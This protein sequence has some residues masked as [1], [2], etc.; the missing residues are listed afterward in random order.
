MSNPNWSQVLEGTFSKP[1]L[2]RYAANPRGA[3]AAIAY[4]H[5]MLLAEAIMPCLHVLEVALRNAVHN[6][7]RKKYSRPDW[8]EEAAS[9][10]DKDHREIKK[11]KEHI[12]GKGHALT[13][14]KVVSEL[15][16][17]FWVSLFNTRHET[18]FWKELRMAFP[19][20]PKAKR[21]RKEISKALSTARDLRNRAAHHD[22][23]LWL[24]PDMR[25]QYLICIDIIGWIDPQLKPW[26]SQFD[27][28]LQAWGNWME[29]P[30]AAQS[31]ITTKENPAHIL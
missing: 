21:Q 3:D 11:T 13:P 5:N 14:D 9:L 31:V 26:L 23:L 19:R 15:N 30:K 25:N 12:Q 2:A 22:A 16:F 20:C 27:K 10:S 6:A 18:E 24:S 8:W 4:A 17:G 28:F 29:T 1:R 7:L